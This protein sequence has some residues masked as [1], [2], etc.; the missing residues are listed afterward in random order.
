MI[1]VTHEMSFARSCADRIVF[2]AD[3]AIVEV[4]GPDAFFN[5]PRT[6]RARSFLASV[7]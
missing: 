5:S 4:A 3:G 7:R 2:M 6:E 1:V